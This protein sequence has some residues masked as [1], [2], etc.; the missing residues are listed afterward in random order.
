MDMVGTTHGIPTH[1]TADRMHMDTIM[2]FGMVTGMDTTMV[3]ITITVTTGMMTHI[4][5]PITITDNVADA[6]VVMVL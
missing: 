6:V 2:A 3:T 1:G 4:H 5:H